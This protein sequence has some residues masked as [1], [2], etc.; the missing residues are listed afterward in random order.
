M[1]PLGRSLPYLTE[2]VQHRPPWLLV[3]TESA[4]QRSQIFL[5]CWFECGSNISQLKSNFTKRSVHTNARNVGLGLVWLKIICDHPKTPYEFKV[6]NDKKSLEL[7]IITD[8]FTLNTLNLYSSYVLLKNNYVYF[9]LFTEQTLK[10]EDFK[11]LFS[12]FTANVIIKEL[13]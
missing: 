4:V 10:F 2:E 3:P 7:F 13:F 5:S 12:N 11:F 9:N 1:Y 6:N 8:L